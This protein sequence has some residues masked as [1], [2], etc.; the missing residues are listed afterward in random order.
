MNKKRWLTGVAVVSLSL[1]FALG[2]AFAEG[3]P[4][5]LGAMF[6]SSGKVGGYGKHGRQAIQLAVDEIN[7]SGGI[8]GR[9]MVAMVEDTK[10]KKDIAIALAEKFINED[11]VDFLMGPTSSGLAMPLTEIAKK[12][13]KI[14]IVTQAAAD[15]LTG[16]KL[17]PYIFSTL[18][19]AMMHA[20]SG[21]YLLA[22][23]PYKRYMCIGPDYS[24]GH[25][26]WNMFKS[27]LKEL[28]PNVE[29]VGELF[30]KFF[31]KDYAT[32]IKQ[33]Q[34]AKPDVVWSPLWG[35]DAVNFI[36]Q[37]IPTGIFKTV[38]FAFPCAGALEVLVPMGK[39][40]P[41]GIY[42]SSR[43]F[44]TTP[45]SSLNRNFVKA[46]YERYKEYPDYMAGETYA[47]VYFIKAAVERAGTTDTEKV[48][49]A[50]EREPLAWDTPEGWKIMRPQ[51]HSVVEDCLWGLTT[52][53]EKYGFSIPKSFDA[54]QGAEICRSDEELKQLKKGQ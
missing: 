53:N 17:H 45:D 44:F 35:E 50:V 37:A 39:D 30:P 20:R 11:K 36:R 8:L 25:S 47:G 6:I 52:Y 23:K 4:I 54:I 12:N 24:Y 46:Y 13:K 51:D 5:K 42:V 16:A 26:S 40:M 22:S 7:A 29:I 28:N 32:Y 10:L 21:A 2:S 41:E 1:V 34:E 43:Y 15:V 33:I 31:A 19:N 18:S 49:A 27:K 38:K 3:P 9:K 48:I 14:L